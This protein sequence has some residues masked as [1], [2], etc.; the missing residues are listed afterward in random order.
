MTPHRFLALA[1]VAALLGFGGRAEAAAFSG[2]V[3]GKLELFEKNGGFCPTSRNCSGSNF[4]ASQ[5]GTFQPLANGV[6][7]IYMEAGI[8]ARVLIGTGTT[9][10]S[11]AFTISWSINTTSLR[12]ANVVFNGEHKQGVFSTRT[13]GGGLYRWDSAA[14]TLVN[15]TTTA[16]PQTL[17]NTRFGTAAAPDP[18]LNFWAAAETTW[19]Y[20]MMGSNK[21]F[22]DFTGVQLRGVFDGDCGTCG[23]GPGKYVRLNAGFDFNIPTVAHEMGHVASYLLNPRH[24]VGDYCYGSGQS[25]TPS[26][27][28]CCN[29][30]GGIGSH[31]LDSAEW[32]H[33]GFEEGFASAIATVTLNQQFAPEPYF[34]T[35]ID[36]VACS[37]AFKYQME[38][39]K[40]FDSSSCTVAEQRQENYVTRYLW[41]VYDSVDDPEYVDNVSVLYW[42][43]YEVITRFPAGYG[44]RQNNDA[45]DAGSHT[46]F[47]NRDGFNGQAFQQRSVGAVGFPAATI[48]VMNVYSHNCGVD[49][50]GFDP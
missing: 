16:S 44:L 11:G 33:V 28:F 50:F 7:K 49:Y 6:V 13:S 21:L 1:V 36:G 32:Q 19:W 48:D 22:N 3:K 9:S 25:C 42:N 23:S 2:V 31:D 4:P 30:S 46:T 20:G 24:S 26:N 37:T 17:A 18:A 5:S 39:S 35:N 27:P 43:L 47:D 40:Q 12:P 8:G 41:D 34:C 14:F 38:P 15:G 29:G 10:S 45:L